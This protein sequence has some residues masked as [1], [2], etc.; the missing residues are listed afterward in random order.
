MLLIG[1]VVQHGRSAQDSQTK[2]G[3]R[4][5]ILG[6]GG[7]FFKSA[8]AAQNREWYAKHL[9]CAEKGEGVLLP[10]REKDTPQNEHVTV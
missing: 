4:G 2:I 9:G 3:A 1:F 8:N 6:I 5:R 10:W 7:V